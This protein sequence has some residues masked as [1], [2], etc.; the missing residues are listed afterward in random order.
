MK[1][2]DNIALHNI[3]RVVSKIKEPVGRYKWIEPFS[4]GF[5]FWK[6][7]FPGC[8]KDTHALGFLIISNEDILK[9]DR[10]MI[11]NNVVYRKPYMRIFSSD[12]DYAEINFETEDELL[13]YFRKQFANIEWLDTPIK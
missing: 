8:F 6:K 9:D 2:Y 5:W 10:M 1:R 3:T 7:K 4:S 12:K 13:S 11:E